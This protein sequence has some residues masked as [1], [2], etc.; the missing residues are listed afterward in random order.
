MSLELLDGGCHDRSK[1]ML[2]GFSLV[3]R[4]TKSQ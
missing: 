3:T 4:P 2:S 1:A